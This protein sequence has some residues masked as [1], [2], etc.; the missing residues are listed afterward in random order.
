MTK[1]KTQCPAPASF[2]L[3]RFSDVLADPVI[4]AGEEGDRFEAFRS[5]LLQDIAPMT[6]YEAVHAEQLVGIEWDIQQHRSLRDAHLWKRMW[7]EARDAMLSIRRQEYQRDLEAAY[8]EFARAEPELA[9]EDPGAFD[10]EPFDEDA[11]LVEASDFASQLVSSDPE[12]RRNAW[13]VLQSYD[14]NPAALKAE[15]WRALRG[16][17]DHHDEQID[18]LLMRRREVMKDLEALRKIRPVDI[19]LSE[20]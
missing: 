8:D 12:S 14:Y 17:L 11:A 18:H 13:E 20:P 16:L 3:D 1:T 6:A 9:C 19:A 2:G 10:F 7:Q 4:L 5:A 15:A